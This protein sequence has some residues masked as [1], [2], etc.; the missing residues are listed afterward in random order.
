MAFQVLD[1]DRVGRVVDHD[2]QAAKLRIGLGERVFQPFHFGDVDKG[3]HCA[4]NHV[5]QRAIGS[6]A[7]QVP[8][9]IDGLYLGVLECQ[10]VETV[11]TSVTK[12][13]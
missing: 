9:A 3:D 6:D 2:G 8:Q 11:C 7:H 1:G 13:S 12:R 5:V 10:G 4:A